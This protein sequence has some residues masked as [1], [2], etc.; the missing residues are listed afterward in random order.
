MRPLL[1][2]LPRIMYFIH[3]KT[4]RL[5]WQNPNR[6]RSA[7]KP[8]AKRV[9]MRPIF[10]NQDN[11]LSEEFVFREPFLSGNIFAPTKK[12]LHKIS[13]ILFGAKMTK[14]KKKKNSKKKNSLDKEVLWMT[15]KKVVIL[16]ILFR[17]HMLLFHVC[18]S[19]DDS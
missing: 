16:L 17:F 5:S 19:C 15:R 12:D 14:K 4:R 9:H 18:L 6:A 10:V 13:R 2:E 1:P 7:H 3:S 8:R 11:F